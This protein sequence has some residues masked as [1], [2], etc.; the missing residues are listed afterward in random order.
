MN[1][2]ALL[3]IA[4]LGTTLVL[5]FHKSEPSQEE[6]ASP[7]PAPALATTA[8]LKTR[9]LPVAA[10]GA[11]VGFNRGLVLAGVRT[12]TFSQSL[13]LQL[14]SAFSL[15]QLEAAKAKAQ[16]ERKPLGFI[17]VWGK[18]FGKSADTR[19]GGSE[20]GL[21]HFYRAFN[22]TLVL[23]YVRHETELGSVPAA[24]QRGFG[25]PDEGG[26]APNMAVV[27]ATATE[28]IVEIPYGGAHSDGGKRDEVFSAGAVKIDQWLATH[29]LAVTANTA[30][31]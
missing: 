17:M 27:D 2:D 3:T 31:R 6:A 14:N 23:V 25:G 4:V 18:L 16:A 22:N 30:N 8:P 15:S 13:T 1:R 28:F 20:S 21:A 5:L 24:V 7:T 26:Y 19:K 11:P 9:V 29:P 12:A 10:T